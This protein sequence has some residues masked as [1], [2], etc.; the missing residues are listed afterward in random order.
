MREDDYFRGGERIVQSGIYDVTHL[1]EHLPQ[2]RVTC[3]FGKQFP[4]CDGCG[5]AVRFKLISYAKDVDT[6]ACFQRAAPSAAR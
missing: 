3:V 6:E 5:E 4:K 2:H 1:E